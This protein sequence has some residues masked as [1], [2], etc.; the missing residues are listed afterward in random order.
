MPPAMSPHRNLEDSMSTVDRYELG[1]V[2]ARSANRET[3][4]GM[5][6][7]F[8]LTR[9]VES[10]HSMLSFRWSCSCNEMMNGRDC[11]VDSAHVAIPAVCKAAQITK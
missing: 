1:L 7:G 11:A 3:N 9:L 10:G 5:K 6:L 8:L 2:R 4:S